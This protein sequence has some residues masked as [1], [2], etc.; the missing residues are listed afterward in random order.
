M[1][2]AVRTKSVLVTGANKG[3]GL[4]VVESILREH[5]HYAV[6]LGSRELGRGEAARESLL[7]LDDTWSKRIE[8]LELDVA[9]D[10]SVSEARARIAAIGAEDTL[11]LYGLVNNAGIGTGR[12]GEVLAV[13]TYGIHRVCEALA[14]WI[15][16]GGRIVNV[17]SAAGPNFVA[18]CDPERQHF[19]RDAEMTW[20]RLEQFM[21]ECGELEDLS[22]LGLG[23]AS[24]YGLSKACANSYTMCLAKRHPRLLVNACTPGFVDTD[25]GREFL[26]ART[27]AE[28]GMKTPA[29]G[30][31]VVMFLLF[32]RPRGTGDYYGSDGLRSPLHRYR[33]PGTPEYAGPS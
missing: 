8:V 27:P 9:S 31:R 13:N 25:L 16:A 4:A 10:R 3:I 30:A 5:P 2:G 1:P 32:G 20:E 15:D 23:S 14:P 24:P 7:A 26:G 12:V 22:S 11:P 33:A 18:R 6:I 28:A 19:F 17:S 29:E 21:Q